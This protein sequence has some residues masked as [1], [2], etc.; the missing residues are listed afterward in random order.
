MKKDV[1]L[2]HDISGFGKCS[3]TAAI[4]VLSVL[5]ISSHPIPTA[6]YTGQGGYPH[7]SFRDMSDM[8]PEFISMWKA[9]KTILNGVYSGYLMDE[10]QVKYVS[11]CIDILC[12]EERLVMVDPVMG[13]NGKGYRIYSD[14]LLCQMKNLIKKADIITPN[15]TEACFISGRNYDEIISIKE[16]DKLILE[17]I[18]LAKDIQKEFGNNLKIV[19]TG[20]RLNEN[21]EKTICNISVENDNSKVFEYPLFEKSFSGTG[22]LFSSVI[23]GMS[24]NGCSFEESV[25]TAGEFIQKSIEDTYREATTNNKEIDGNDGVM[26]EK[27]LMSLV[28][29]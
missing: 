16:K 15:L 28:R 17:V 20:V 11:E 26:Y 25:K 23:Y 9:N 3:M 4:S 29:K 13:D 14:V 5:G 19:I 2:F 22:D 7:F 10:K 12:A 24:L 6:I 1:A 18:K 8:M 21:E 27:H